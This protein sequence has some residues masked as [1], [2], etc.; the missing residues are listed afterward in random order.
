[1]VLRPAANWPSG[2]LSRSVQGTPLRRRR[3][4]GIP[5]AGYALIATNGR[6]GPISANK[7][8][9]G[10]SCRMANARLRPGR[11]RPHAVR[12]MRPGQVRNGS[13]CAS[14]LSLDRLN[15]LWETSELG[16]GP[17][18]ARLPGEGG[19]CSFSF[20][21]PGRIGRRLSL[22]H[23]ASARRESLPGWTVTWSAVRNG[24]TRS[25]SSFAPATLSSRPCRRPALSLRPAARNDGTLPHWASRSCR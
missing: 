9:K 16:L 6:T 15:V 14:R 20:P 2:I 23:C 3:A 12:E 4:P 25:W 8:L 11:E 24:G 18:E 10:Q 13:G 5:A 7:P 19:Q 17:G 1:M 21:T 22:W